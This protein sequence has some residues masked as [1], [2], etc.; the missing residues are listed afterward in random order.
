LNR[1]LLF[2]ILYETHKLTHERLL[3][4][5]GRRAEAAV[6]TLRVLEYR[7]KTLGPE[8]ESTL[9]V[10]DD[11]SGNLSWSQQYEEVSHLPSENT[12]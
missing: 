8:H 10:L 4:R 5:G 1:F 3:F 12:F 9:D 11:R 7:E 6:M 2:K